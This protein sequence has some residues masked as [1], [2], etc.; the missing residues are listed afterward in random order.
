MAHFCLPSA[1]APELHAANIRSIY[2]DLRSRWFVDGPKHNLH[3][4]HYTRLS[5]PRNCYFGAPVIQAAIGSP[6]QFSPKILS[7]L[8][9]FARIGYSSGFDRA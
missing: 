1:P 2:T 7:T 5:Y 8:R 3:D 9:N 6:A 4:I